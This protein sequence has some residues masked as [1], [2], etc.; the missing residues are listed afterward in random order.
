MQY[1]R[2]NMPK[3]EHDIASRLSDNL[4]HFT[5]TGEQYMGTQINKWHLD[6]TQRLILKRGI[7]PL[8]ML[9][10]TS[11]DF[12]GSVQGLIRIYLQSP[13]GV[14]LLKA[15]ISWRTVV[16]RILCKAARSEVWVKPAI[17]S[18]RLARRDTKKN[19][20][21]FGIE[22]LQVIV[23]WLWMRRLMEWPSF[24]EAGVAQIACARQTIF[25]F[26]HGCQIRIHDFLPNVNFIE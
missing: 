9:A 5:K 15:W 1:M 6:E 21:V 3:S 16:T 23:S 8:W 11:V 4:G 24:P 7:Q 22:P 10:R 26:Q 19:Q 14:P 18:L 2:A 17:A 12:D 25:V 13:F 20:L